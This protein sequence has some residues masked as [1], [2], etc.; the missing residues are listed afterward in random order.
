MPADYYENHRLHFRAGFRNT[1]LYGKRYTIDKSYALKI[2]VCESC[3]RSDFL[4][5]PEAINHDNTPLGKVARLHSIGWSTGTLISA[6]GFLFLTPFIPSIGML[7]LIKNY[8]EIPVGLGVLVLMATWLS[9]RSQQRKV[10]REIEATQP[11]F[12]FHPRAEVRTP[13]LT[14]ADDKNGIALEIKI[15]NET[16][17][18]E[19]ANI[20]KFQAEKL[21]EPD[22]IS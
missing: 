17:A 1:H 16:W 3:Y 7:A 20:L 2:K 14:G 19:S 21:N 4:I 10:R 18:L 6:I 5:A 13:I 9:Q 22:P 11:G 8:W 15:E 12:K